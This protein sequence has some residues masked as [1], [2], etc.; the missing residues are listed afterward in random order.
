[1]A[2]T[3]DRLPPGTRALLS[4]LW[5]HDAVLRMRG[6][7]T[8]PDWRAY[9]RIIPEPGDSLFAVTPRWVQVLWER[10][11]VQMVPCGDGDMEI[12]R[13]GVRA[14][15][16]DTVLWASACRVRADMRAS[17]G[18]ARYGKTYDVALQRARRLV[19]RYGRD[20]GPDLEALLS[21]VV[22]QGCERLLRMAKAYE[23]D[24]LEVDE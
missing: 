2:V 5:M 12:S 19:G 14:L 10:R 22:S 16:S 11:L 17:L 24:L 13:D 23:R 7:K 3:V 20:P 6:T 18:A 21:D 4:K 9:G 8:T 1:M 15:Q